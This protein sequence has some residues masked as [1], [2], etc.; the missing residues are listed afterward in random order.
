MRFYFK[1]LWSYTFAWHGKQSLRNHTCNQ[2]NQIANGDHEVAKRKIDDRSFRISKSI[3]IDEKGGKG[4]K[5]RQAA[6]YRPK[7]NPVGGEIFLRAISKV[8]RMTWI[9]T[10]RH[11]GNAKKNNDEKSKISPSQMSGKINLR[12]IFRRQKVVGNF[13]ERSVTFAVTR[14]R[15]GN[16]RRRLGLFFSNVD[17]G[18]MIWKRKSGYKF[19]FHSELS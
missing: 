14:R 11:V 13:D 17:F 16:E 7:A 8:G 15:W 5:R 12:R 3:H 9:G 19:E 4:H 18:Q 1:N 10:I 2:S 6:H